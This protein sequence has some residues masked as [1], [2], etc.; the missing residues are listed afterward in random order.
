VATVVVGVLVLDAP[1]EEVSPVLAM[2]DGFKVVEA[3]ADTTAFEGA[4]A[5][6][7]VASGLVCADAIRAEGVA[8]PTFA[9]VDGFAESAMLLVTVM[10]SDLVTLTDGA[11]DDV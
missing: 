2:T 1:P 4:R 5:N 10:V 8:L 9:K 3:A 7:P 6:V 11:T